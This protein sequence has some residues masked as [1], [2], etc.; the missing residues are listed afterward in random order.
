ML[1]RVAEPSQRGWRPTAGDLAWAV[2]LAAVVVTLVVRNHLLGRTE[3]PRLELGPL[4]LTPFGPLA[5]A[6]ILFG[7]HLARRWCRRFDLDWRGLSAALLWIVPGGLWISHLAALALYFP[8]RLSD[9]LA[10]LDLRSPLSSFG[11]IFGG[12]ALLLLWLRAR[13]LPPWRYVDALV[14]AF[15]GGYAFGRAGCFA[16]HDHPGRPT[17]LAVGVVIGGVRRHDL[18][19]YEL[20]LVIVLL[21]LLL[22]LSWR[23]RPRD[24]LPT[25]VAASIYAPARFAFDALRVE[26]PRWVGLTPGQWLCLPLAAVALLAWRRALAAGTCDR[27]AAGGESSSIEPRREPTAARL[28]PQEERRKEPT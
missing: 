27:G 9:P 21:A 28:R 8:H 14:F 10:L 24:G 3:T 1:W 5:V 12:A 26:D 6:D 11:G 25:A 16:V 22:A 23:G 17:D 13:G 20:A 4:T 19:F 18:G 15:V 2:A 7:W